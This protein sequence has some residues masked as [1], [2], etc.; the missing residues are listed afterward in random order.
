MD[1]GLLGGFLAAGHPASHWRSR[2]DWTL[3][4]QALLAAGLGPSDPS[5]PVI[6]TGTVLEQHSS[7][8][9]GLR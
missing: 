8:L 5:A 4:L 2:K 7:Q 6:G 1:V 9:Q 3:T